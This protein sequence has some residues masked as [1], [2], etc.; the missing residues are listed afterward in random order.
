MA[1]NASPRTTNDADALD[2]LLMDI[3]DDDRLLDLSLS[4]PWQFTGPEIASQ[5]RASNALDPVDIPSTSS[6]YG[7]VQPQPVPS[8]STST[9]LFSSLGILFDNTVLTSRPVTHSDVHFPCQAAMG[10]DVPVPFFM[11]LPSS[12]DLTAYSAQG[13]PTHSI[14][15]N[16]TPGSATSSLA[17]LPI[18]SPVTPAQPDLLRT[19]SIPA[20]GGLV[21]HES[22]H[23]CCPCA[24]RQGWVSL[25]PLDLDHIANGII[26]SPH[27]PHSHLPLVLSILMLWHI[28]SL[29][30]YLQP[31]LPSPHNQALVLCHSPIQSHLESQQRLLLSLKTS[32]V[33][34][35]HPACGSA[36]QVSHASTHVTNV[37]NVG[38]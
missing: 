38:N 13:T 8:P 16:I 14:S 2:M 6:V 36:K 25:V 1:S 35:L 33:A 28:L 3:L 5:N 15:S 29:P 17:S 7:H 30:W 9:G 34:Q 22:S 31:H 12:A 24:M 11:G 21:R 4:E 10:H 32:P 23:V 20:K 26:G 37:T 18:I 19:S 27:L